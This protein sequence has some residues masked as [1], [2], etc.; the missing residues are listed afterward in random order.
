MVN[1]LHGVVA[2][3]VELRP[4]RFLVVVRPQVDSRRVQPTRA[5]LDVRGSN[6][7]G[8][9]GQSIEERLGLLRRVSSSRPT[10]PL[11]TES[12]NPCSSGREPAAPQLTLG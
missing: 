10:T 9:I 6:A 5:V 11:S 2:L 12:R 1:V 4:E 8:A 7:Q 3:G